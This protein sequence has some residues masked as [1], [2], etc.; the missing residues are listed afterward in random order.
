MKL[1]IVENEEFIKNYLKEKK[2][3]E[4]RLKYA[5]KK[6]GISIK[7]IHIKDKNKYIDFKY[8]L[9]YTLAESWDGKNEIYYFPQLF[10]DK[11]I[12]NNLEKILEKAKKGDYELI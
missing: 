4:R 1:E 11:K 3:K 10:Y 2:N 7:T 8:Y 9:P 12:Y 5:L 6:Y